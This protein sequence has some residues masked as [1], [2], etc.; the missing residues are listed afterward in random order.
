MRGPAG[1]NAVTTVGGR[2]AAWSTARSLSPNSLT[3]ISLLL[4][5]C[6]AAWFS[7]GTRA[8]DI[9]A[10]VAL[11]ACYLAAVAAARL[12]AAWRAGI[13]GWLALLSARGCEA[14]VY[15]A[16]AIGASAAGWAGVWPLAVAVL[17]MVAVHDAMNACAGSEQP[18]HGRGAFRW[19]LACALDMPAGGRVLLIVV[20][21]PVW[22]GRAAL[23]ALLDWAVISVGYGI[24]GKTPAEAADT[25]DEGSAAAV[26]RPA[27]G[28]AWTWS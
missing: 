19:L 7:A 10:A 11:C 13:P 5:C 20:I 8:T 27:R 1:S 28:L 4:G 22:G 18:E 9:K 21:T 15:A 26:H 23:L 14:A 6:A 2:L 3:G 12:M 25:A 16:L 24:G 17:S